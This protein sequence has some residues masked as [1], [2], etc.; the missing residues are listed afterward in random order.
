MRRGEPL[1]VAHTYLSVAYWSI[2]LETTPKE[3]RLM[4]KIKYEAAILAIGVILAGVQGAAQQL[5]PEP[6]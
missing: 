1:W 2:H 6:V 5:P 4:Q 3:I